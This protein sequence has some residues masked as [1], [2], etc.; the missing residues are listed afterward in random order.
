MVEQM[1]NKCAFQE[2]EQLN[3]TED[4]LRAVN[5]SA[6]WCGPCKMIKPFSRCLSEEHSNM[7]F[8]EVHMDDG[9]GVA[10]GCEVNSCQTSSFK[11]GTKADPNTIDTDYDPGG[12]DIVSDFLP[13]AEE[14]PVPDELP[15]LPPEFGDQ[16]QSIDL[17]RDMLAAEDSNFCG[18]FM[19]LSEAFEGSCVDRRVLFVFCDA[20]SKHKD[21]D[22]KDNSLAGKMSGFGPSSTSEES[23][24]LQR[25]GS[26]E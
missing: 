26:P 5:F 16:F 9:Q 10:T 21:D 24:A 22:R 23:W 18:S 4:K 8:L 3:S 11:K 17:S 14:F 1:E 2:V 7:V 12:Y 6:M 19:Y 20:E 25:V 15:S 13:P